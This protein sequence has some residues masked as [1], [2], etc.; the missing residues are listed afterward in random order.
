MVRI[1]LSGDDLIEK[2]YEK[3]RNGSY[4]LTEQGTSFLIG[5]HLTQDES[6]TVGFEIGFF[7][8]IEASFSPDLDVLL[9]GDG[10]TGYEVKG[11]RSDKQ[12]VS[13]E[14]L[15]KGLGQAITLLNQPI[16]TDG[17][18]LRYVSLAYPEKAEFNQS[19]WQ[20]KEKFIESLQE[21]PIGLVTVG[22]GGLETIIEPSENPF[23]NSNL[24]N[25]LLSALQDQVSGS[26][27]RHPLRGLQNLSLEIAQDHDPGLLL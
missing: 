3:Y 22:A 20:W 6:S 12:K 19:N 18:A 26:N 1:N 13:K 23:Y 15:Y 27:K 8:P 16:G 17:G 5:Y 4:S 11:Y 7:G 24:Q 10:L 14:Q 21:T 2:V 25:E 9:V